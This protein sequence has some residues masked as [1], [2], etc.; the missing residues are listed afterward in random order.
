[1]AWLEIES[2]EDNNLQGNVFSGNYNYTND[3]HSYIKM[4]VNLYKEPHICGTSYVL[5]VEELYAIDT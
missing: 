3:I 4:T 5:P 1:M 2:I